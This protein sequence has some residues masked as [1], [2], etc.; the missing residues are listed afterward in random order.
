M[1]LGEDGANESGS[2]NRGGCSTAGFLFYFKFLFFFKLKNN[3]NMKKEHELVAV[4]GGGSA[5]GHVP[6]IGTQWPLQ[7]DQQVV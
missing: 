6:P 1:T 2:V 3:I 4:L 5:G 7:A